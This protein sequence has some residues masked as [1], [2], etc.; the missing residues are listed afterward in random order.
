MGL[1]FYAEM[2]RAMK[3][4]VEVSDKLYRRAKAEAALRGRKLK[5]LI[6]EELRLVL[7]A[8]RHSRRRRSLAALKKG[9]RGAVDS[10]F[11]TLLPIG[12]SWAATVPSATMGAPSPQRS[13][14][15][16]L[17]PDRACF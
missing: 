6:E 1:W 15:S 2:G 3:T 4:T 17:S 14:T 13:V 12:A 5:D 7:E 10:G 8:P 16:P 11:R 9:A